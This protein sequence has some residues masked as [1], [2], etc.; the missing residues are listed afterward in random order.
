M[1]TLKYSISRP[2]PTWKRPCRSSWS[3]S[4]NRKI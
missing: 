4:K 1:S 3:S 2:S